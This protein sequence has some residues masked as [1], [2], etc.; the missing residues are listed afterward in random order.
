MI[1][2]NETL[3]L[4]TQ[5]QL[6]CFKPGTPK[7]DQVAEDQHDDLDRG[8]DEWIVCKACEHRVTTDRDRAVVQDKHE[9]TFMN[10]HAFA[11]HIGCFGQ[12]P[13][14][15]PNGPSSDYWTWFPGYSWQLAH[16]AGCGVHLGWLFRGDTRRFFGLVLDRLV[17]R[18]E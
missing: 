1:R 6:W 17:R 4:Q 8:A 9:H 12:A 14:V 11:Y 16:C 5:T 3:H 13:G 7:G 15:V 10:P 2:L 18:R